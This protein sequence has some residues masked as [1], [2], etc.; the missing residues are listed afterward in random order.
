M[1]A[2][3][4]VEGTVLLID[5]P[6]GWSSFD[7]VNKVR[8]LIRK[9]LNVEKIKVGHAGTLDPLA[10]GLLVICTGRMTKFIETLQA[11]DKEY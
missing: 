7:V 10:T 6:L 5:K 11:S 4:L 1:T 8:S 2:Q 3:E 9:R